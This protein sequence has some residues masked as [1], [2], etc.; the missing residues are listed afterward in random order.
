MGDTKDE[1]SIVPVSSAVK[2]AKMAVETPELI[3]DA[4]VKAEKYL[5]EMKETARQT[6][7]KR[8]VSGQGVLEIETDNYTVNC[9]KKNGNIQPD[10]I[11][12]ML[13][14]AGLDPKLVVYPKPTEYEALPNARLTLQAM[15][16]QKVIT[17]AQFDLCFKESSHVVTIKPKSA[18]TITLNLNEEG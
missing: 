18:K 16:E 11:R 14:A 13:M 3:Y 2:L 4:V 5:K 10:A 1:F 6:I 15:L 8:M 7:I 17:Q 9:T 12:V